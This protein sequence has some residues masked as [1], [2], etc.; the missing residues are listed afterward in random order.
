MK[1]YLSLIGL[2]SSALLSMIGIGL[3]TLAFAAVSSR[4]WYPILHTSLAHGVSKYPSPV[5]SDLRM[6]TRST[7]WAIA[8]NGTVWYTTDGARIWRNIT[9]K[10]IHPSQALQRYLYSD[11]VNHAWYAVSDLNQAFVIVY[12]TSN[13]GQTWSKTKIDDSGTPFYFQFTDQRHGWLSLLQGAA[14]GSER[15]TIYQTQNGGISWVKISTT[16]ELKHG[17]MPFGGDKTGSSFINPQHGWMTGYSAVNGYTYLFQTKNDGLTWNPQKIRIQ[18]KFKEAGFTSYPPVFL[19]KQDGILP[20]IV[21]TS[22]GGFLAYRT[23][24]GGVTWTPTTPAFGNIR[25]DFF[26]WSLVSLDNWFV[27]DGQK[28]FVTDDGGQKW[29]SIIPNISFKNLNEIDFVSSQNGWALLN[30]GALY[31]TVDGGRVWVKMKGN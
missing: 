12:R 21:Y 3:H 18:S 31:H 25:Y 10:G 13:R 5:L 7:G 26:Q 9:P 29:N 28:L 1:K 8:Q 6:V 15:E 30:S 17:T 2:A 11:D 22:S 23:I 16:N 14:A 4:E 20:F 24:N 19:G 27:T